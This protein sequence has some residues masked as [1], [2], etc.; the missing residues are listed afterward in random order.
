MIKESISPEELKKRMKKIESQRTRKEMGLDK[1]LDA[2]ISE[3]EIEDK[4]FNIEGVEK[5]RDWEKAKE[6]AKE[7]KEKNKK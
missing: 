5:G 1:E 3:E 6:K 7:I 2:S 4:L